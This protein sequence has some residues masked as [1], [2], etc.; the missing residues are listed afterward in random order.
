MRFDDDDLVSWDSARV[1][2]YWD[3]GDGNGDGSEMK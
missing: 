1:G 2:G 3:C